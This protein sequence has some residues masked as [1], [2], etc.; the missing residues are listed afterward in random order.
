MYRGC[1]EYIYLAS[2][3]VHLARLLAPNP[4][5][6]HPSPGRSSRSNSLVQP[7]INIDTC[8]SR[9]M[10]TLQHRKINTTHLLDD[11]IIMRSWCKSESI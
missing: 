7:T 1:F 3:G 5:N 9:L 6:R 2:Q 10:M 11:K 8:H 4:F